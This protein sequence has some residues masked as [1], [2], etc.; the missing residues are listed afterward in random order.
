MNE[1]SFL[2]RRGIMMILF[3]ILDDTGVKQTFTYGIRS[4]IGQI[5][6]VFVAVFVF[7]LVVVE[8]LGRKD[9]WMDE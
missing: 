3:T 7:G 9:G 4:K 6:L 1:W 2:S 8:R 5:F